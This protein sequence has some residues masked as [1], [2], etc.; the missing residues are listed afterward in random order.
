MA[1]CTVGD[2]RKRNRLI[3]T[4]TAATDGEIL[5]Y[6]ASADSLIDGYAGGR[7]TVPLVPVPDLVIGISADLAAAWAIRDI[8]GRS[9][10]DAAPEQSINLEESAM[11]R[12]RDIASGKLV[13]PMPADAVT[14]FTPGFSNNLGNAPRYNYRTWDPTSARSFPP[15]A[16]G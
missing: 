1:Y 9:G 13:L 8:V 16:E 11:A 7:F 4:G 10:M 12:L 3:L 6:I 2:V 15:R 14:R 5:R